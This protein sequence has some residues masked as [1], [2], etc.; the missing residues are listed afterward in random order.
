MVSGESR[1]KAGR[2]RAAAAERRR[3]AWAWPRRQGAT[4]APYPCNLA[5]EQSIPLC[6]LRCTTFAKRRFPPYPTH[7]KEKGETRPRALLCQSALLFIQCGCPGALRAA[8]C[9][10][11]LLLYS[12]GALGLQLSRTRWCSTG[13]SQ[14]RL[15]YQRRHCDARRG[16]LRLTLVPRCCPVI[17][18]VAFYPSAAGPPLRRSHQCALTECDLCAL[19]SPPA[20]CALWPP[21]DTSAAYERPV[22][23][24]PRCIRGR[25][26]CSAIV[27]SRDVRARSRSC[28]VAGASLMQRRPRRAAAAPIC[29][30]SS[31]PLNPSP[32]TRAHA[33]VGDALLAAARA[34]A[35]GAAPWPAAK[36]ATWFMGGAAVDDQIRSQFAPDLEALAAGDL[37]GWGAG[38]PLETLA[39]VIIADQFSRWDVRAC[40]AV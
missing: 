27:S 10:L 4:S 22:C 6:V 34:G 14:L 21:L 25:R 29:K 3:G 7:R 20:A 30:R 17:D 18:V 28:A 9:K 40:P 38:H 24:S 39:G 33:G 2:A 16:A 35:A 11:L 19:S 5:F 23:R 32:T 26:L 37:D 8:S 36:Q 15:P 13:A 31:R 12:R 1:E